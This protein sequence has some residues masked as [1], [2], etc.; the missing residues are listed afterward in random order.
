LDSLISNHIA[1]L[2][3]KIQQLIKV[4]DSLQKENAR[5]KKELNKGTEKQQQA[6]EQLSLLQQQLDAARINTS[7]QSAE[8]KKQL[9]KRIDMYLKEIDKCLAIINKV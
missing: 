1:Q 7:G 9:S 3:Q 6:Q 8:E 5:L 2:R 4:Q